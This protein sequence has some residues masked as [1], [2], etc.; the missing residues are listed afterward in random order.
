[1]VL[2]KAGPPEP[3]R[4]LKEMFAIAHAMEH[5]AATQYAEL[6]RRARDNGM[7][8]LADVFETLAQ[9]ERGHEEMVANWSQRRVGKAPDWADIKWDLP[10]TLEHE[11]GGELA[12]S[13]TATA[14]R[15]LSMAVRNEERAFLLWSYIA[16][17]AGN[18]E[19]RDAAERMAREELGHVSLLRR[20]RRKAY[21]AERTAQRTE[22]PRSV[23]DRFA[24]AAVLELHL[25]EALERLG[26]TEPSNFATEARAMSAEASALSGGGYG[27]PLRELDAAALAERL[28]EDYL[29]IAETTHDETTALQAQSLAKRAISRLAWLRSA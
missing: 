23:A 29:D 17:E 20:E 13:R 4:S 10:E 22:S 21:H 2:L 7:P 12:Q 11:T 5:E 6:G 26:G 18:A 1:M 16:A 3:V 28:V 8:E 9:E 27:E 25:A 19:I 14:Y 24:E 15:I